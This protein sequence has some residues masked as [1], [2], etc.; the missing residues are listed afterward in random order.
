MAFQKW[1][2][3]GDKVQVKLNQTYKD[4][5]FKWLSWLSLALITTRLSATANY[6][7]AMK[8]STW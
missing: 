2:K 6:G 5:I 1:P 4:Y 3:H 7:Y 8:L